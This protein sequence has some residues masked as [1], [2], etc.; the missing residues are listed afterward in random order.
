MLLF[1]YNNIKYKLVYPNCEL[2][3]NSD[4]YYQELYDEYKFMDWPNQD[5]IVSILIDNKLWTKDGDFQLNNLLKQIDNLKIELFKSFFNPHRQRSTRTKLNNAKQSYNKYYSIRH[6]LDH[7]TVEGFC[8]NIK[9][10]YLLYHS[11][12][13]QNDNTKIADLYAFDNYDL[14]PIAREINQCTIDISKFRELARSDI[15]KSYWSA[16]KDLI[17]DKPT[18][19]LTDEQRTLLVFSRM[20]D[21]ARESPESPPD[22]I[23]DDDDM[24]DG[25]LLLQH[26]KYKDSKKAKQTEL[27]VNDKMSKAQEMFIVAKN[28]DDAIDVH[29]L[30]SDNSKSI[31]RERST[32]IKKSSGLDVTELPDIKREIQKQ[33]QEMFKQKFRKK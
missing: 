4:I 28:L 1:T 7:I 8:E 21:S 2:K 14:E 16:N 11:L 5:S 6:C 30:N 13:L 3:Y 10:Q 33:S 19:D 23:F 32:A 12:Y 31:I 25:W 15:W 26:E 24:F 27:G 22:P 17:F 29:N 9:N 18:I 20:Y